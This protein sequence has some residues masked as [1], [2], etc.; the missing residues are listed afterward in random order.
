M[1]VL[2]VATNREKAPQALLPLGACLVASAAERAGHEVRLVDLCFSRDP[3]REAAEAAARFGPD[4]I[5]LSVRNL[6]NCDYL[7]PHS[8]LPALGD[9]AAALGS[10]SRAEIVLGG[11]AVSAAPFALARYLGCRWAVVGAGESTFPLFLRAFA[12]GADPAEIPGVADAEQEERFASAPLSEDLTWPQTA[13]LRRWLNLRRYWG[14]GAAVPLQTKRGCAFRCSYCVY[15]LLEGSAWRLRE[16]ELVAEEA[17]AAGRSGLRLVEFVDSVF[18]L[19]RDHALACCEALARRRAGV[20]LCAMELNPVGV[21]KELVAAMNAA[22]F[23]GVAVTAESGSDAMLDSLGKGFTTSD[24]AGAREGL[25][26]LR[27]RVLWIFMLG[28]P[29]ETPRT[30][31][32]TARFLDSL[33]SSH[34]VLVTH[35]LRVLPGTGLQRQLLAAGD[36]SPEQ[37]LL[38]PTFYHSPHLTPADSERILAESRFPALSRV[39]LSDGGHRLLPL[40]QRAAA[41]CRLRPPYWRHMRSLNRLRKVLGA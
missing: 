4:V 30:V 1:K 18:G 19:P 31:R 13:A 12:G 33:P 20:P 29:G 24:L 27:A 35:G 6:D 26:S 10:V 17:A 32:E 25:R 14:H 16:P 7:S 39:N 40:V 21:T 36:I 28:G 38:L 34:L 22:D 5:G 41:V 23:S 37:D 3:L 9:L 11:P 15:P 2:V 8:Y